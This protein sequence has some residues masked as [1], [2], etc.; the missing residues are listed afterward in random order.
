MIREQGKLVEVHPYGHTP[1]PASLKSL[2]RLI[3]PASIRTGPL[4]LRPCPSSG[5]IITTRR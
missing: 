5:G 2:H 4:N 3:P 1:S